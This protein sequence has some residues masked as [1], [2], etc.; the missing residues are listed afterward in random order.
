MRYSFVISN[1]L[2]DSNINCRPDRLYTCCFH[3]YCLEGL[4]ADSSFPMPSN[5][6]VV[7]SPFYSDTVLPFSSARPDLLFR[8]PWPPLSNRHSTKY[9]FSF[10]IRPQPQW[11][12]LT[13]VVDTIQGFGRQDAAIHAVIGREVC[14]AASM[15]KTP[16]L[17]FF[18]CSKPSH[19]PVFSPIREPTVISRH[20]I[21]RVFR[22]PAT[23]TVNYR[24]AYPTRAIR[25]GDTLTLALCFPAYWPLPILPLTRHFQASSAFWIR[26]KTPHRTDFYYPCIRIQDRIRS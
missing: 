15:E 16:L 5:W 23:F 6:S 1:M 8:H 4:L 14:A 12:I 25:F 13:E 9:F 3:E 19:L 20:L 7:R 10:K 21:G 18:T 22:P 17:R 11:S 2:S 26:S 24:P